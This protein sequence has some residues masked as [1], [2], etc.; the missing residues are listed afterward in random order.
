MGDLALDYDT[1]N[2]LHRRRL[3]DRYRE[4]GSHVGPPRSVQRSLRNMRVTQ[5]LRYVWDAAMLAV[6][7]RM[8][9]DLWGEDLIAPCFH[10]VTDGATPQHVRQLFQCPD[11]KAFERDLDQLLKHRV[12][13]SLGD[14][15]NHLRSGK[16]LPRR[17]VFVSF[18]DGMREME[19]IV[20]RLCYG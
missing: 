9:A 19:E 6:P 14:L 2:P 17:S 12:P 10:L 1:R 13:V 7:S 5:G 3:G 16:T 8:L 18:D 11:V 4:F 20:A 15:E